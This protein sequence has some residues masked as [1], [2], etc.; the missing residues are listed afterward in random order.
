MER[1]M[2][3]TEK[4]TRKRKPAGPFSDEMLDQL[5]AQC[6]GSDV[7]SLLGESGLIGQLKKQLAQRMLAAELSHH[8]D[9]QAANADAGSGVNHRNGS[10]AKTVLTPSG[11]LHLAIPRDRLATF[12]PALVAKHQRRLAGFDDHVIGMYARG[13]SV[14]EIQGHL[15]ELYG[16]DVSPQLIST[17]TDEV[18][19][20][21]VEW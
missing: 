19:A 12:E 14:R 11:E 6:S 16:Q 8:L 15:I 5:L 17:I 13:M 4:S 1:L 3:D 2:T 9:T 10:S 18:M 20:E 7:E 21:A